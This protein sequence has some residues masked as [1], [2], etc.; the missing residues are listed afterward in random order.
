M[1][2]TCGTLSST[3]KEV[4]RDLKIFEKF[5]EDFKPGHLILVNKQTFRISFLSIKVFCNKHEG[6]RE[7]K[8]EGNKKAFVLILFINF[9]YTPSGTLKTFSENRYFASPAN[10]TILIY[11]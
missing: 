3:W 2:G 11:R 1:F 6:R 8:Y 10:H 4:R 9:F 5:Q 7:R